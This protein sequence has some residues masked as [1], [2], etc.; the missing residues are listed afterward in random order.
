VGDRRTAD[1]TPILWPPFNA[2]LLLLVD[3]QRLFCDPTSPAFCA[4]WR[5]AEPNALRL[6][7]AFATTGAPVTATRHMHSDPGEPW[8]LTHFFPRPLLAEDPLAEL[9]PE[10][11]SRLGPKIF[12]KDRFDALSNPQLCNL[13]AARDLLVIAGVQTHRCV[14]ATALAAASLGVM[15]VVV[16]DAC[17]APRPADHDAALRVLG[18]AHALVCSTDE[19]LARLAEVTP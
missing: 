10:F 6:L 16:A 7:D 15:P 1:N 12:D 11:A 3:L 2:P 14:L 4:T 9:M 17:A 8:P 13:V 18:S 19:L 5:G